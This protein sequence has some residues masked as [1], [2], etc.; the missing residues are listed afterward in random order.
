MN[1]CDRCQDKE[2]T[3]LLTNGGQERLCVSCYNEIM[4]EEV[5]VMLETIPAEIALYDF[6][7]TS[8]NFMLQQHLYPNGI[9][10]QAAE[11]LEYGYRF[12]VHGE[13]ECDQTELLETLIEKVKSGV[14]KRFIKDGQ[15]PNGQPYHSIVDDE[16]VGRIDHDENSPSVSMIVIDGKPCTWEQ[17]GEMVKSFEGFQIQI[18]FFDET[19][20]VEERLVQGT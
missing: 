5:G 16:L 19:D 9:F 15:F 12:A 8:R 7:G 17:L 14:S 3:I 10:M 1:K 6:N 11:D 2:A 18:K 20:D 13:L 4:A